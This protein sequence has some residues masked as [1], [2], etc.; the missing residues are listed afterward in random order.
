[1]I[2]LCSTVVH[3]PDYHF[4]RTKFLH[5]TRLNAHFH[6]H[7][8][9][10]DWLIHHGAFKA[11][12]PLHD[13]PACKQSGQS[14][15]TCQSS[16]WQTLCCRS[17]EQKAPKR[18]SDRRPGRRT[19]LGNTWAR[20]SLKTRPQPLDEINEYFGSRVAMYFVFLSHYTTAL[21]WPATF[22]LVVFIYG[23][24]FFRYRADDPP[25]R[26]PIV[27]QVCNSTLS[28]CG[29]CS[30]CNTYELGTMCT[31][32]E[33]TYII[34][35]IITPIFA[36]LMALWSSA[37]L[38]FWERTRTMY[39]SYW[40]LNDTTFRRTEHR[41]RPE[42]KGCATRLNLL[43]GKPEEYM[44]DSHRRM[45][46]LV[47]G[48]VMI[49]FLLL[50][51]GTT[52]LYIV[53]RRNVTEAIVS[54]VSNSESY[55]LLV[56][57]TV[58]ASAN[59]VAVVILNY[60]F[61][62]AASRMTHFENHET[63]YQHSW[64]LTAKK[65]V[66]SLIS[67]NAL[68]LNIVFVKV[69]VTATPHDSDSINEPCAP[70]GC[71]LEL[72]VQLLINMV[73]KQ[74]VQDLAETYM[75]KFYSWY[76]AQW[77]RIKS[78]RKLKEDRET[79]ELLASKTAAK[80]GQNVNFR[81]PWEEDF[82]DDAPESDCGLFADFDKLA[83]QFSFCTF[84]VTALPIAPLLAFINNMYML[85]IDAYKLTTT[86]RRTIPHYDTGISIWFRIFECLSFLGVL[87]TG[88]VMAFSSQVIPRYVHESYRHGD[89]SSYVEEHFALYKPGNC[90]F[91]STLD[92]DGHHTKL[93]LT[94]LCVRLVFL[95]FFENAVYLA[96][97][98][99]YASIPSV[100][101]NVRLREEL[102][103][104]VSEAVIAEVTGVTSEPSDSE[105]SDSGER[106]Q[107][108]TV[109]DDEDFNM[110]GLS[111]DMTSLSGGE[112]RHVKNDKSPISRT[113]SATTRHRAQNTNDSC[114]IRESRV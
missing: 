9:G 27:E 108:D 73:C 49:F 40:N 20:F 44:P 38:D 94:I 1:M 46:Y 78:N 111:Q 65:H 35:N 18:V 79:Q 2:R 69:F 57:V 28:I 3:A 84:F 24:A 109:W 110:E 105:I 91:P 86:Y 12:F 64:Y 61:T 106:E 58:G 102:A 62:Y 7:E 29:P 8:I 98:A 81:L 60:V 25:S 99:L 36:F 93:S 26:Q 90:S 77:Q 13:G 107:V 114:I 47:S 19:E 39:V 22:G 112:L 70:Y 82:E 113:P 67:T 34:D 51:Y 76:S 66:F 17:S 32:Y 41:R 88:F 54:N 4:R 101:T 95:I 11:A 53:V 104:Y 71:Q 14:E 96:K 5:K 23:L 63:K 103:Q 68:C 87:S 80:H 6:E 97:I 83:I 31:A 42:F 15:V 59:L 52:V 55:A 10:I 74:V 92:D 56:G 30:S 21:I 100:P 37:F 72:A 75:P 89:F 85:R 45:R 50:V 43:T 16:L 48:I 33:A